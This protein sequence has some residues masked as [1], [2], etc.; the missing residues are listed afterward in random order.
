MTLQRRFAVTVSCLVSL[1][2]AVC[3][4]GESVG[5]VHTAPPSG[6][7]HF[8]IALFLLTCTSDV[9]ASRGAAASSFSTR[10]W[11]HS[12]GGSYVLLLNVQSSCEIN[13]ERRRGG[14]T[15]FDRL[16]HRSLS[17]RGTR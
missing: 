15:V 17:L 4:L 13:A 6:Q 11:T 7:T 8:I 10:W 2:R 5:N 3:F 14:R 9:A 1:E 12:V 16:G